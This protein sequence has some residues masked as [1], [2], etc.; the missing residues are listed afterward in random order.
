VTTSWPAIL[1]TGMDDVMPGI[2]VSGIAAALFLAAVALSW[3]QRQ[4]RH[5]LERETAMHH[6]QHAQQA[7][8]REREDKAYQQHVSLNDLTARKIDVEIRVLQA[9]LQAA[10]RDGRLRDQN[11]EY[12]RLM[13]EKA[14]LEIQSLKLHIREQKKRNE[15]YSSFDDES[16]G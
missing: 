8:H 12:H 7:V 2:V 9:Q 16:A 4:K 10:E 14:E 1:A 3:G 6:E 11:E 15:D 5:R 13:V